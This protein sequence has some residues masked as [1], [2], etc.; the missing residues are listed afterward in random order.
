MIAPVAAQLWS[1]HTLARQDLP[2]VLRRIAEIGF[3]AVEPID[4]YGRT[5][6]EFRAL[7]DE[8]GLEICSAHAPFPAGDDGERTLDVYQ[9]LGVDTLAWSLEAEEL[10]TRD[11]LLRGLD[12]VDDGARRAAR[13]G[14]TIAYHNHFAEFTGTTDGRTVY[15]EL[16]DAVDPA[17]VLEVDLY[18]VAVA[19]VDPAALVRRLGDR[20]RLVHAKDGPAQ[21]MDDVMV[22]LG[23]GAVDVD[24]AIAACPALDWCVVELDRTSGDMFDALRRSYDHV[25]G[26]GLAWGHRTT[27]EPE[28]AR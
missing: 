7:T 2:G 19:G 6:A 8:V 5:P 11:T 13:R 3:V 1:V 24:P 18:W 28:V 20:V 25:V 26:R 12:R 16:L 9:E 22:A 21:G 15:D 23:E 14:M 4:L 10:V 17:V 27:T